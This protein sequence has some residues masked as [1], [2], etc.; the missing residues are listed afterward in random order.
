M[1]PWTPAASSIEYFW[2]TFEEVDFV[3]HSIY[4]GA[5]TAGGEAAWDTVAGDTL[6]AI[7]AHDLH[8]LKMPLGG[9]WATLP[10]DNESIIAIPEMSLQMQCL[11]FLRQHTYSDQYD[12]THLRTFYGA[13]QDVSQRVDRCLERLRMAFMCAADLTPILRIGHVDGKQGWDLKT[14]HK[15]R[16]VEKLQF[17]SAGKAVGGVAEGS[18]L[19]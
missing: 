16:N 4:A 18:I 19:L 5:P 17:W 12:Y 14:L 6:V 11:N 7:N 1:C 10:H 13:A 2:K 9:E 15:C 3:I 8:K